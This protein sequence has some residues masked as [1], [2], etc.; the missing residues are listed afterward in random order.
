MWEDQ[1]T[2]RLGAQLHV[3]LQNLP[4]RGTVALGKGIV[5]THCSAKPI[6]LQRL[7]ATLAQRTTKEWCL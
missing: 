2:G 6:E 4:H 5:Q 3:S 1:H 7:Q